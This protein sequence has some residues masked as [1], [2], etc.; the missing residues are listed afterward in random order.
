[1]S[2]PLHPA[3]VHYPVACWTLAALA[4]FAGLAWHPDWLWPAAAGLAALGCAFGLLAAGAGLL[5]L[6]RLGNGHPA[7]ATALWH[8][9]LALT[10]WCVFAGSLVAR[11]RGG[12]LVPPGTLVFVLDAAGLAGVLATGWLGGTLVYRH[13]VGVGE[14]AA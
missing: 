11:V 5:E 6:A 4:D 1:M 10:T 8:M 9:L 7:T 14:R 2:H 13:G 12:A 3:L